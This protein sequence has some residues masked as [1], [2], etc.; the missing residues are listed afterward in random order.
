MGGEQSEPPLMVDQRDEAVKYLDNHGSETSN[1]DLVALR[2]KID[3]HLLPFMFCCYILQFLDKVM[4][5]VS[6][7]T[8]HKTNPNRDLPSTLR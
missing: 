3:W 2:R 8:M 4:L 1:V 5:N 7:S 6:G